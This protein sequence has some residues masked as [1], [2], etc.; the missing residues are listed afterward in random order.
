MTESLCSCCQLLG[1]PPSRVNFIITTGVP[2]SLIYQRIKHLLRN[3]S[4]SP[5][6]ANDV[7]LTNYQ[8]LMDISDQLFTRQNH[9]SAVAHL[10]SPQT[11]TCCHGFATMPI[12]SADVSDPT[13]LERLRRDIH[14][15]LDPKTDSETNEQNATSKTA[16]WIMLV[17]SSCLKPA[18]LDI[19]LHLK[20]RHTLPPS[21]FDFTMTVLCFLVDEQRLFQN[22][23]Y[24]S[25]SIQDYQAETYPEYDG[26]VR[27][28]FPLLNSSQYLQHN[29]LLIKEQ[30]VLTDNELQTLLKSLFHP[31]SSAYRANNHQ[32]RHAMAKLLSPRQRTVH[33]IRSVRNSLQGRYHRVTEDRLQPLLSN[34]QQPST[35]ADA[36]RQIVNIVLNEFGRMN[37]EE[38]RVYKRL[39]LLGDK[40]YDNKR[41][42]T[43]ASQ[44][45][46]YALH[47]LNDGN[48]SSTPLVYSIVLVIC[49][50][51]SHFFFR[52]QLFNNTPEIYTLS[53]LLVNQRQYALTLSGLRLCT[54]I[55]NGDQN[56]H[57]YAMT[58]LTHDHLTA[59][60]ILDAIRWLLSPYQ[61]L[62]KLWKEEEEEKEEKEG[63]T[64]E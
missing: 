42:D 40:S 11:H 19:F 59:R 1:K 16:S 53:L 30:T 45:V 5:S 36:A 46:H 39:F 17:G 21:S 60:K 38:L 49:A 56:E 33:D 37:D 34:L 18:L 26:L 15:L 20:D 31:G 23:L 9:V 35:K 2:D 62:D 27:D 13:D 8:T 54:T 6:S 32:L 12:E 64:S 57:K 22:W 50:L 61:T 10:L 28:F 43:I 24:Q 29:T 3:Y 14:D 63:E 55:L 58:Y 51:G 47:L 4:A 25:L 44:L 48:N 7:H 52:H 41:S